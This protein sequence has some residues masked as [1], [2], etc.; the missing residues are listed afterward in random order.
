MMD[1]LLLCESCGHGAAIHPVDGCEFFRCRCRE[2]TER[3]VERA[4]VQSREEH[5]SKWLPDMAVSD[6][7]WTTR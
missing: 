2:T 4:V 7:D 1:G 5:R 3:I 6:R